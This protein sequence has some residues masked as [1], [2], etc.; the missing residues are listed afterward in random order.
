MYKKSFKMHK[1]LVLA[2]IFIFI[3][4]LI[5]C[6]IYFLHNNDNNNSKFFVTD[7]KENYFDVTLLD[8]KKILNEN[9]DDYLLG[10]SQ[11]FKRYN[12]DDIYEL[13]LK[14]NVSLLV[15]IT[16]EYEDIKKEK[17]RWF[18][19]YTE[20]SKNDDASDSTEVIGS[21]FRDFII[22]C[23]Q[24]YKEQVDMAKLLE[25]INNEYDEFDRYKLKYIP[26]YIGENALFYGNYVSNY[27]MYSMEFGTK[28]SLISCSLREHECDDVYFQFRIDASE[29]RTENIYEQSFLS[30][31]K[32]ALGIKELEKYPDIQKSLESI[33]TQLEESN[34]FSN[35]Q[36]DSILTLEDYDE[37]IIRYNILSYHNTLEIKYEEG[38]L[39]EIYYIVLDNSFDKSTQIRQK[40][41][42]AK[43]KEFNFQ[44]TDFESNSDWNDFLTILSGTAQDITIRTTREKN[45]WIS[46]NDTSF[47]IK[48]V[49]K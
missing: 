6:N 49:Y 36:F 37:I 10:E 28:E 1:H 48:R 40:S 31:Q 18:K 25:V 42:I 21:F 45:F 41:E 30:M 24:Y 34:S 46:N 3:L 14:R 15:S 8:F 22:Y 2:V 26:N 33:I 17:I 5:S 7:G 35:L 11:E 43:L 4:L 38:K 16:S 23:N 44:K 39:D 27:I 20:Y 12:S 29:Y 19:L 13:K 47:M 9:F 32:E